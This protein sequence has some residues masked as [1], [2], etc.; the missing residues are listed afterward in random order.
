MIGFKKK[1]TINWEKGPNSFVFSSFF[2]NMIEYIHP[3]ILCPKKKVHAIVVTNFGFIASGKIK[4]LALDSVFLSQFLLLIIYYI[5]K[6]SILFNTFF[7]YN[8]SVI[9]II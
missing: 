1:M 4:N 2:I 3:G 7:Y 9:I 5:C 6:P 8:F